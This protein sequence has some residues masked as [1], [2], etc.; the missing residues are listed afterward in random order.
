MRAHHVLIVLAILP[1]TL[2]AQPAPRGSLIED[3]AARKLI[4]A[5]DSRFDIDE[6]AKAVELWQSVIERYPAS[7]VRL[8]AHM[9]LGNYY[10]ERE[11]AYERARSHFD[12][13]A[14]EENRDQQ[15][16]AEA[17]LKLGECFYHDRNYGK[18]FQVMRDVIETFP[19]SPQVNHAYYYIGLGHF[20]LGHYSRAIDALEKVG[21]T[22][23]EADDSGGER[24]EAGKRLFVKIED[25]DLAVL[26]PDEAVDV[27]CKAASGDEEKL[28]CHPIGRNVRLVL[29][30]LSTRLGSPVPGNGVLEVRGG[31]QVEVTY[32]D[33]HTAE[34]QLDRAVLKQIAVVGN[35]HVQI[36]D[37]AFRESLRGVVLGKNVNLQISDADGDTTDQADGIAAVVEVHRLKSVE[38]LEAESA[39]L[40]AKRD[41]AG[42]DE[43]EGEIEVEP[44]KRVD[45][46]RV[47]LTEAVVQ[48]LEVRLPN[49]GNA[50]NADVPEQPESSPATEE[51][52]TG[53]TSQPAQPSDPTES[54]VAAPAVD[55]TIHSGV[56][57]ATIALEKTDAVVDNDAI[58]QALPSDKI[59]VVYLDERHRLEGVREV[60][61]E[62]RCLEGNIG[63]VRVT[64][65]VITDA[66]LRV[67]TQLKTAS[68]LT[69]IAS[70][71]KEFGLQRHA[72][73]KYQLALDVCEE[74][75]DE[76]RSM[77]GRLLE[78]TYVQL[79]KI[80]FEMDR[81]ELAAAMCQRLQREFPNS[82]FVDDALLQLADVARKEQQFN[83]A[84]GIYTR[85]V[86]MQ[87]SMLRG[88]AQ[89]GI[90]SCYEQ[91]AET[92]G[93]NAAQQMDR[94]FQEYKKVY[95]LFPE[96]GRV[97]EAVAKM[98][99]Y[100]YQQKDYAR[101]I[102]TFEN[103]LGNHPDAKFLDVILFNYGRCLF[104][105]G[106]RTEAKRRFDQLIGE[107]PESPLAPD[108]KK[109]SDALTSQQAAT[110][111]AAP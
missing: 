104:R 8:I 94:A 17:M 93:A 102:D 98:A 72:Q 81:L 84:I 13:V 39:A 44:Y 25:A 95:D 78:E 27:I 107:F 9:R 74:I 108:A 47:Q 96:S 92:A 79:W 20:Q 6:F 28:R 88:E 57:R 1:S 3:R 77:G 30:S 82:G 4:E 75:M 67:Q 70:R 31:D 89:F 71:Y 45:Q 61:A 10:L 29:G 46:V 53:A 12:V 26:D 86:R 11:R 18:C 21:T 58:L 38:E 56:F 35:G 5:G 65:A 16:R 40:A 42:G 105:M 55:N 43:S 15:Q 48:Q 19:V 33:Q 23:A 99:N 100:Y 66:E 97:G 37:G 60:S 63:G 69:N 54:V 36:T 111:P 83:R 68:A 90:A 73:E 59:R 52:A 50:G 106:R 87:T 7:R 80:Y 76:V 64:R 62:A 14:S 34:K 22:L 2:A 103:V 109:I 110:P 51:A 85:L 24:L 32:T 41:A 49:A 101:A 91:M